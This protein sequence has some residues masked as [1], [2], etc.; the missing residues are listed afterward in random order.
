MF[1]VECAFDDR[2][3][4]HR[5][6]PSICNRQMPT[7]ISLSRILLPVN[8]ALRTLT[9]PGSLHLDSGMSPDR[10]RPDRHR[11][12]GR[13]PRQGSP[14]TYAASLC[15]E[16]APSRASGQAPTRARSAPASR[17]SLAI[18]SQHIYHRPIRLAGLRRESRYGIAEV[19]A[20]ETGILVDLARE[21]AFTQ[22]AER[23]EADAQFFERGRISCSGSLHHSEYSL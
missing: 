15:P 20:V 4:P 18:A 22:R 6:S 17:V 23:N 8:Q 10:F 2:T 11:L 21:I 3:P 9:V 16:S 1:A 7:D 14:A 12:I 13:R 5:S 19:R